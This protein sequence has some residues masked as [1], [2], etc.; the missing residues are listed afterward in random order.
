MAKAP[1]THR[2]APNQESLLLDYAQRLEKH[3]KNRGAVHI[4][5]SILKPFNRREQY[6]RAAA[7]GFDAL[8]KALQGQL[9]TLGNS[10]LLFIYKYES[11]T[12]VETVVQKV[13][14]LFSDDPLLAEDDEDNREFCT[15]YDAETEYG[16][17]LRLAQD[18]AEAE[19]E[20]K[21]QQVQRRM[22][23][24]D[25]LKARET[26]GQP[27]TPD[28]LDRVEEALVRADLSNLVRRQFVCGLNREM[29]PDQIF[30]EMFISI[31]DLRETLLPDVNLFSD[32]WLFQHL[33]ETLDR[34][35]LSMLGKNDGISITGDIS[36]NLN[37]SSLLSP[38]FQ[39]FDESLTA[40]RRGSMVVE[41]Q[42]VDIFADLGSYLFAREFVQEK[43]Y[44][45][46][47]DGLTYLTMPMIDREKL[48]ADYVKLIWHPEMVDGGSD[49][50]GHVRS[51]IASAD[52]S[53][54]IMCRVDSQEAVDFGH[55]MGIKLFQGRHVESL[56]VENNRRRELLRLKN[57]IHRG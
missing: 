18:M 30:S 46:L 53:R 47:V 5:L 42:K 21:A 41:L 40:S 4:R 39:A 37:I 1:D 17:I 12:Q 11:R 3:K 36:F 16:K 25:Q 34:R 23:A 44:R 6:I 20:R 33:T 24:R 8:I 38:E 29:V 32:L 50:H 43:G 51:M 15:W 27:L 14:F 45:V 55:M 54:V 22:G 31:K 10:D 7:S 19:E 56:I 49:M 2:R 48:G 52:P 26:R 9:F 35:M 13:R 28:V 57:R